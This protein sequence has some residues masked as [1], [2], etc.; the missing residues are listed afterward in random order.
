MSSYLMRHGECPKCEGG[1]LT[2]VDSPI[3]VAEIAQPVKYAV[4]K[5]EC[6]NECHLQPGEVAERPA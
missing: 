6:S 5:A 4:V 3:Y 2:I 1:T